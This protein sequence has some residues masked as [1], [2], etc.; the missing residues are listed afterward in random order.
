[1]GSQTTSPILAHR[2]FGFNGFP[3]P[4]VQ[5]SGSGLQY[6]NPLVSVHANCTENHASTFVEDLAQGIPAMYEH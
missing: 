2:Q 1:M 3:Q 4:R 5:A 6:C